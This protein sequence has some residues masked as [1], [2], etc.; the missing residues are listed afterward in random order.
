MKN[1]KLTYILVPIVVLIWGYA[2]L[3]L[4]SDNKHVY[5][6]NSEYELEDDELLK[7]SLHFETLYFDFS[8]PFLNRKI[9]QTKYNRA[10]KQSNQQPIRYHKKKIVPQRNIPVSWPNIIYGGTINKS[11]ALITI[12]NELEI[13]HVNDDFQSIKI[14]QIYEDSIKVKLKEEI[15]T[16]LR[17][18]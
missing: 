7:D 16:I 15:K 3:Q 8:D 9:I 2:L 12:N 10:T 6:S 11:K 18:R 1:K 17:N 14:L 4:F 5:T 13:L